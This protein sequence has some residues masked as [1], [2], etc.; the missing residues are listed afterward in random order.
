MKVMWVIE[1]AKFKT[2]TFYNLLGNDGEQAD[3]VFPR[4]ILLDLT[5]KAL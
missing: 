3:S 2:S 5:S 1:R 4:E